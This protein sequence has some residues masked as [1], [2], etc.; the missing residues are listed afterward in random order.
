MGAMIRNS[1]LCIF[2]LTWLS[3]GEAQYMNWQR[4]AEDTVYYA[5]EH[6]PEWVLGMNAGPGQSWDFRSLKAPYA[7]SKR[8]TPI[9]ERDRKEYAYLQQGSQT[10][11][12]LELAGLKAT[13]TQWIG[14]NPVCKDQN[15]TYSVVPAYNPF[16]HGTM[17]ESY[18]YRGQIQSAFAWPRHMTCNWS[19]TTIPDSCRITYIIHE[20]TRVDG[21]G[22]LYLPTEV[23]GALRHRVKMRKAT[24]VEVKKGALWTDVT[25]MVPGIRLLEQSEQLRFLDRN[26]GML[27]AEME[28]NSD[29]QPTSVLFKTHPL[30]TRVVNEEP[31]RP[32]ILA[33]PNPSFDIIRFQLRDLTFGA[34]KMKIFNILGVQMRELNIQ[35]DDPRE[36]ISVDLSDLQRGT[37]LYRLQDASGRTIRTKKIVLISL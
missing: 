22:T 33:Y 18:D 28:L 5:R 30:I 24:R 12:V 13:L 25:T 4:Y 3:S 6:F 2:F 29:E 32:D 9:G 19:P 10:V 8:V 1:C 34:Y 27:L 35:V 20:H 15:L 14:E 37:Y 11:G 23:A 21:D 7:I 36:T 17:G 26:S 31:T 16:F